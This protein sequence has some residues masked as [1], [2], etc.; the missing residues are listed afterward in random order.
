MIFQKP[1]LVFWGSVLGEIS[2]P[3][4]VHIWFDRSFDALSNEILPEVQSSLFVKFLSL[5][6]SAV[7]KGFQRPVVQK[8]MQKLLKSS[9]KLRVLQRIRYFK[10]SFREVLGIWATVLE[11]DVLWLLSKNKKVLELIITQA[12]K[13]SNDSVN[14]GYIVSQ[15]PWNHPKLTSA[16]Q[17]PNSYLDVNIKNISHDL[18]TSV[19]HKAAAEPYIV[20]YK[21]DHPRHIFVNIIACVLLRALCYSSTLQEFNDERRTIK[22]MLLY[23]GFVQ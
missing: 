10:K 14:V 16:I 18:I 6:Y 21:S 3:P 8:R 23:N 5:E 17:N 12:L 4:T 7:E 2:L 9:A 15:V 20:P 1:V 22:L 19:Y 11:Q 13:V